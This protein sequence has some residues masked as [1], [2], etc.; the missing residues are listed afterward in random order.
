MTNSAV[1]HYIP[2]IIAVKVFVKVCCC[3]LW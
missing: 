2:Q 3:L 1:L